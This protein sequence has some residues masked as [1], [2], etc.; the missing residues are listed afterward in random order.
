M[1]INPKDKYI[2][3]NKV[4]GVTL[5]SHPTYQQ[6]AHFV[7]IANNQELNNNRPAIYTIKEA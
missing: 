7:D 3:V 5:E 4:T 1:Q 2:I 6:A